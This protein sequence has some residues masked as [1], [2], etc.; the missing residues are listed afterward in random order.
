MTYE[1][2]FNN[3]QIWK[4]RIQEY[5]ASGLTQLQWCDKEDIKVSALRYWLR[6]LRE[7]DSRES[8]PDW[9]KVC[10]S[11]NNEAPALTVPD[12][13]MPQCRPVPSSNV[14]IHAND[15]SIEVPIDAPLEYVSALIR[16]VSHG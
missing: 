6:K 13:R 5:Q 11:N 3:E 12:K 4:L 7:E 9:L 15:I 14:C 10:V 8:T 16:V 1:E 2:R